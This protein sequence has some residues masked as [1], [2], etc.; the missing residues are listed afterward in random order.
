MCELLQLVRTE[1]KA[2]EQEMFYSSGVAQHQRRHSSILIQEIPAHYMRGDA[3]MRYRIL[4]T[5]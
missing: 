1:Q 2:P 4:R 3:L 5:N